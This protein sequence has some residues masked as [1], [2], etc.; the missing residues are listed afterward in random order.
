VVLACFANIREEWP[1]LITYVREVGIN[2]FWV[3][4]MTHVYCIKTKS[5]GS[6]FSGKVMN[7]TEVETG[8]KGGGIRGG[9][10]RL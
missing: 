2:R 8:L 5:I 10:T 6:G 9:G 3:N 1:Q 7:M 4:V